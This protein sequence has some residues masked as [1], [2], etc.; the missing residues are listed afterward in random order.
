MN[1]NH[2]ELIDV[3]NELSN[4]HYW[5]VTGTIY[6]DDDMD[7]SRAAYYIAGGYTTLL[8]QPRE[9]LDWLRI[10][11]EGDSSRAADARGDDDFAMLHNSPEFE[12]L[13]AEFAPAQAPD[14]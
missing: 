5:Y 8:D 2:L 7:F 9:A 14:R 10:A 6:R 11:L 3:R 12:A 4:A 13:L 1:N